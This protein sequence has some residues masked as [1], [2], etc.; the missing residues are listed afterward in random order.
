MTNQKDETVTAVYM[1]GSDS[2]PHI[3]P[4]D[5]VG[6]ITHKMMK[7]LP[8]VYEVENLHRVKVINTRNIDCAILTTMRAVSADLSQTVDL[9]RERTT[10]A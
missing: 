8:I 6:S 3:L 5:W 2:S 10:R 1:I 4:G 7:N 9:E